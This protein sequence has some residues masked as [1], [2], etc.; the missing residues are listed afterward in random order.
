[1][2]M[3]A[4]R[5][6]ERAPASSIFT[7]PRHPYTAGLLESIPRLSD[8]PGRELATIPG[9]PPVVVAG[10]QSGCPFAPRC[11]L[12]QPECMA[13]APSLGADDAQDAHVYACL[14]PLGTERGEV[15]RRRNEAAGVTAAISSKQVASNVLNVIARSSFRSMS[16]CQGVWTSDRIS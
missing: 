7:A 13:I 8:E 3:Y 11:P 10:R 6:V 15:A 1:M 14:F 16:A 9:S 12:A 5:I 4:G 2:V